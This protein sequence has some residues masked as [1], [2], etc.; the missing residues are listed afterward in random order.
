M[1][2]LCLQEELV[3]LLEFSK[4]SS[5]EI[6]LRKLKRPDVSTRGRRRA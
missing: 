4:L 3:L 6:D 1:K 2:F 5:E